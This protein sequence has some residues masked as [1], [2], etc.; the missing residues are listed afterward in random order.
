MNQ[1]TRSAMDLGS[2]RGMITNN[3]LIHELSETQLAQIRVRPRKHFKAYAWACLQPSQNVQSHGLHSI[4][5][6]PHT[7]PSC[8]T[9]H[10]P[11][12]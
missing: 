4:H 12:G 1:L 7:L 11:H 5:S 6:A 8:C 3:S 2:Q 9:G 10:G